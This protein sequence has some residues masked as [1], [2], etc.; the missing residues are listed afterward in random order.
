[1]RLTTVLYL[2]KACLLFCSYLRL[3]YHLSELS[4][5]YIIGVSFFC[6][7]TV[8]ARRVQKPLA[9]KMTG[10]RVAVVSPVIFDNLIQLAKHDYDRLLAPIKELDWQLLRNCVKNLMEWFT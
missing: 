10:K 8:L 4:P 2:R 9:T 1:M 7:E 5:A 6:I 3:S